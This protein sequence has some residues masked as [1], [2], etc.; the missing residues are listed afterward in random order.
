MVSFTCFLSYA[1]SRFRH[2]YESRSEYQKGGKGSQE[3]QWGQ[4]KIKGTENMSKTQIIS[5]YEKMARL[6]CT[7]ANNITGLREGQ[8]LDPS[9]LETSWGGGETSHKHITHSLMDMIIKWWN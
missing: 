8:S 6:I 3:G 4:G 2:A 1:E 7:L 9:T 5:I